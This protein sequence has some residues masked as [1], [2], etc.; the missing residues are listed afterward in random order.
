[1]K[2]NSGYLKKLLFILLLILII[3]SLSHGQSHAGKFAV[4]A[5]YHGGLTEID[6]YP[7]GKL[8]HVI[9]S[10][11][12]L[13]GNRM[14]VDNSVDSLTILHLVALKQRNPNL[15][16]ILSLGGWGGCETCPIVFANAQGREEFAASVMGLFVHYGVDGL[17]LDW[18]YPALESVPGYPY[19]PGDRQN[20]TS[21]VETL[22]KTVGVKYELSFAAGGFRDFFINSIEWAKVMPLLNYVN[23][24]TYDYVN[25]Y[26]QRTGHHTLLFSTPEQPESADFAVHFL[27]SLGV[28]RN[29]M[30]IGAAFY[31]RIL[32]N[33]KDINHGLY[34]AGT[35]FAYVNYKDFDNY[36][37]DNSG[38]EFYWDSTA[39]APYGY[40]IEKQLFATFDNTESITLKTRYALQNGL[41]GIMFWALTGDK[42]ENG[43]LDAI[44]KAK[45]KK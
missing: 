36:F 30:V 41:G 1:M 43:L 25:G 19:S 20:F 40:N 28:P 34:Q 4:I 23:L 26:S 8:T 38:F 5:Y 29:K 35:F 11:L 44:N 12:H 13:K 15:K 24:M 18:E 3:S 32:S 17:D 16:I 39:Q 42:T 21:L 9:Y 27:D 22:R 31:A 33:V 6:N 45:H 10:F 14:V 37:S 2:F 7:V